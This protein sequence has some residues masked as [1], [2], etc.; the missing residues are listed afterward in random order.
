MVR[1]RGAEL[2]R[3][4]RL[5][6]AAVVLVVVLSVAVPVTV[7]KTAPSHDGGASAAS[8][9]YRDI[10]I[11]LYFSD[12][13]SGN[14]LPGGTALKG[15]GSTLSGIVEKAF[16]GSDHE[17]ELLTTG[18]VKSVDGM[19]AP[20]GKSWVIFQWAPPEGWTPI[21]PGPLADST[22]EEHTSYLLAVSE[23][24][25][26]SGRMSYQA[27]D[28]GGPVSLAAFYLKC[29]VD[30][31]NITAAQLGEGDAGEELRTKL[32]KGMWIYGYG[33]SASEA[34]ADACVRAFGW[35]GPTYDG[36][37][38]I[39]MVPESRCAGLTERQ[40][41]GLEMGTGEGHTIDG[42]LGTFLG[43]S[44]TE[45]GG[46]SYVYWIQYSW[47]D[48]SYSWDYNGFCLG[49]YDP[50]VTTYFGLIHGT[51][52]MSGDGGSRMSG[53]DPHDFVPE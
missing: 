14:V 5:T 15:S 20:D 22:L 24:R 53:I 4:D 36:N 33:S 51:S 29:N 25:M 1:K 38:L 42:Y 48:S 30:T 45:T 46:D 28:V 8:E 3:F 16:E 47:S 44:D 50:S 10:N 26:S 7:D 40:K 43:L 37:A 12:G 19:E 17:I 52:S 9:D 13:N 6:I 11:Y 31:Y 18:A 27:P 39:L 2:M 23:Y 49:Y 21:T 35:E 41:I 34:F 32:R